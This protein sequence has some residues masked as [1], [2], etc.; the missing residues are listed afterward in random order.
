MPSNNSS[1]A[2]VIA[3][4]RAQ[5]K[6][7]KTAPID[8]LKAVFTKPGF[9][10]ARLPLRASLK[11]IREANHLMLQQGYY[12]LCLFAVKYRRQIAVCLEKNP[13]FDQV[14]QQLG[15]HAHFRQGES[16]VMVYILGPF[17]AHI[18]KSRK[19]NPFYL[20]TLRHLNTGMP[21]RVG[22]DRPLLQAPPL[23]Q[24]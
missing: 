19:E 5:A 21:I 24:L 14:E 2:E 7:A 12:Y 16:F 9:A 8:G 10:Y 4:H 13:K 18:T 15:M 20:R 6:V 1:W 3:T 23:L 17:Q 22:A 11:Q